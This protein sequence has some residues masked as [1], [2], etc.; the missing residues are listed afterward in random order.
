[1]RPVCY[2]YTTPQ[3]FLLRFCFLVRSDHQARMILRRR[4]CDYSVASRFVNPTKLLSSTSFVA[5]GTPN[6][7]LVN[8]FLE[9]CDGNVVSDHA[10]Q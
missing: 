3:L 4:F 7:A 5:V 6:V 10:R 9:S 2:R 8:F 1:M